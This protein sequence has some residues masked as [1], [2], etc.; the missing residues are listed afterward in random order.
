MAG[1]LALMGSSL[2]TPGEPPD[3]TL[4]ERLYHGAY[5]VQEYHR[6]VFAYMGPPD[7]RP[8][9]PVLDTFDLPGYQLVARP[10]YI[11]PCNWLQV[12]ENSMDLAHLA[13]LPTLPGSGGFTTDLA[14]L[15]E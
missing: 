7:K 4:K 8:A 5:P 12:K 11:W 13:F 1:A 14:A 9:F 6:L 3:S 10:G 15:G 2:E